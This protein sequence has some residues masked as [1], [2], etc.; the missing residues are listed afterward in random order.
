MP[1][2]AA[3]SLQVHS[4]VNSFIS[5]TEAFKYTYIDSGIYWLMAVL[6]LTRH[7]L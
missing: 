1:F 7:L 5:Y 2:I 4:A 6:P 3:R